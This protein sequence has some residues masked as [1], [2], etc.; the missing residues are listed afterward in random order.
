MSRHPAIAYAMITP[1]ASRR[2]G[3]AIARAEGEPAPG[4]QLGEVVLMVWLIDRVGRSRRS[5]QATR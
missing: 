2:P 3:P 1:Q 5:A 4:P